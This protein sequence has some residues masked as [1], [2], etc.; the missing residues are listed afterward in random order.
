L[1]Y[2]H[3]HG[4]VHRD[5]KPENILLEEHHA[6]VA[7]FGIAKALGAASGGKLTATGAVLGAPEYISPEQAS[8]RGE[9]DGRSDIYA[10]GCVLFEMLAGRPPFLGPTVESLIRQHLAAAAP[11]LTIIRPSI[12]RSM[13]SAIHRALAKAP[14][15]RF[16]SAA[17]FSRAMA[18]QRP[19]R[20]RSLPVRELAWGGLAGAALVVGAL[21]I[22]WLGRGAFGEAGP[23]FS[24]TAIAVLP[25]EDLSSE[26]AYSFF[27][28]G[29]HDE[30]LTQ[31]YK[32]AALKP[33]G[34]SSVMSYRGANVPPLE[35]VARELGVG[36][37]VEGSV[38]IVGTRLRVNVYLIDAATGDH[39]W[40][41]SYDRTLDDAFA[42]QSDVAQQIVAAVGAA[43]APAEEQRL[44]EAP[45]VN[46][47]AY[48][49]YLRAL[50]YSTRPG[51]VRQNLQSAEQLFASALNLDPDFALAHAA[52]SEVHGFTHWMGYDVLPE[53]VAQQRREAEAALRLAPGLP[54]AHKAMGLAYYHSRSWE[55]ALREYE[56][57]RQGLP[58]DAELVYWIAWVHRRLR[59]WDAV[60]EGVVQAVVLNPRDPNLFF[61]LSGITLLLQHRYEEAVGAFDRAVSL[62]PDLYEPATFKGR[63][64][65]LWRGQTD[66]LRAVLRRVP[67]DASMVTLGTVAA[68]RLQMLRWERQPDSILVAL[69][70]GGLSVYEAQYI[71]LPNWL[72]AAW[73]YEMQGESL[74][75]RAAFDSAL[76]VLDSVSTVPPS[77]W[78]IHTARGL[79][80]AGLGRREEAVREADWLRRSIIYRE[81]GY[82]G[83]IVAQDRAHILAQAGESDAALSEIERLLSEPS[84]LSVHTL[85]L[86]PLWDPIRENARF[87]A[88][89]RR[90]R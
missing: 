42:I 34:R 5:I 69:S 11:D 38:Q 23:S 78:R 35:Q 55:D 22:S 10:L 56:I 1:D 47:E 80:L 39:L 68:E 65:V 89:L 84:F 49:F 90:H 50:E 3:R 73:A 77:D 87:E 9:L 79:A 25:L 57:A 14:A 4:V 29:L 70:H 18:E 41:Q 45:T 52:I 36:S 2:A 61:D 8:G 7:D 32:V 21:T 40:S 13:S 71:Y 46:A 48:T 24:R 31:L 17:G 53:R 82:L 16:R 75:A 81:D 76:V 20:P 59:K 33:I 74:A 60:R 26:G 51:F 44:A 58:N 86:D 15:D 37:V 64:Y 63:A 54:Q 19:L 28:A 43:L 30:I 6:V 12:P 67:A 27:A 83:P 88:L 62:A 66:T 72:Y 85:R